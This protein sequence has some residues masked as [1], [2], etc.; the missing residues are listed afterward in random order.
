MSKGQNTKTF[1]DNVTPGHEI[2]FQHFF[3]YCG[4]IKFNFDK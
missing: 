1:S 4:M 2:I 3:Y